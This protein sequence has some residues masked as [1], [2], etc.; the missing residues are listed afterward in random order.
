MRETVCVIVVEGIMR[1]IS[2]NYYYEFGQVNKE[3]VSFRDIS[4]ALVALL[5]SERNSLCNCAR[6]YYEEQFCEIIMNL[7]Q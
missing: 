3:E 5:F 7:G 2:V 4:L 6:R 1:N